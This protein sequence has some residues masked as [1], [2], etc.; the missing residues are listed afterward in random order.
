MSNITFLSI[1]SK[2]RGNTLFV[3]SNIFHISI[4]KNRHIFQKDF[5]LFSPFFCILL[6]ILQKHGYLL[7]PNGLI[8]PSFL[9]PKHIVSSHE[10]AQKHPVTL[11]CSPVLF[12][13]YRTFFQ[14]HFLSILRVVGRDCSHTAYIN[15]PDPTSDSFSQFSLSF[16]FYLLF[17]SWSSVRFASLLKNMK[18]T[19]FP[20][21]T[22]RSAWLHDP[23][24][25]PTLRPDF[26]LPLLNQLQES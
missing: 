15:I 23:V 26:T 14:S 7:A 12:A 25:C 9:H 22:L 1:S 24:T 13:Q 4:F 10:A 2:N 5:A 21:F 20:S 19:L 3:S 16:I 18:L 11:Y 6:Q 17:S 8:E